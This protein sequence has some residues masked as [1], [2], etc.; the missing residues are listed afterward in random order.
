M[1]DRPRVITRLAPDD[2]HHVRNVFDAI[3]L[4]GGYPNLLAAGEPDRV[5]RSYNAAMRRRL[6]RAKQRCDSADIFQSAE[7]IPV[8]EVVAIIT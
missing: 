8:S 2:S 6:I 4:P 7:P 1:E 5:R 3:T